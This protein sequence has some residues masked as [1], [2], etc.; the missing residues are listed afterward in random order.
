MQNRQNSEHNE[1]N[2]L[3]IFAILSGIFVLIVMVVFI[4]VIFMGAASLNKPPVSNGPYNLVARPLPEANNVKNAGLLLPKQLGDFQRGTLNGTLDNFKTT[5]Q[6]GD[7]RIDIS[8]S[9]AVSVV[10]AQAYVNRTMQ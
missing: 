2:P 5:Y 4:A 1:P 9:Q 3:L 6:K 8:G 10:S 7:Y